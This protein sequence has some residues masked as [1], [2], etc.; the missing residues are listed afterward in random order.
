MKGTFWKCLPF[1]KMF[2][3]QRQGCPRLRSPQP[4]AWWE[5]IYTF[6][7]RAGSPIMTKGPQIRPE[8]G[9]QVCGITEALTSQPHH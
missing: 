5:E 1:A 3:A 7:A 8:T 6:M 2:E 9:A 4:S